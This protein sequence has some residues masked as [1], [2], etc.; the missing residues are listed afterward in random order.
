MSQ[1]PAIQFASQAP[2][3]PAEMLASFGSMFE[4]AFN[5]LGTAGYRRLRPRKMDFLLVDGNNQEII[6][7]DRMFA[8]LIGSAPCNHAVWYERA[9]APGQEPAA[10]D[11]VWKMPTPQ[12]FPDALP[13]QFHQKV[14]KDGREVWAFQQLRR[15]VWALARFNSDGS[16]SLELDRPFVFDISSMSLYGKSLPDQNM[17]KWAGIRDVCAKYSG[18]GV[19]VFP[20]M[21]ITQIVLD[22]TV[23]VNGPVM[24]RPMRDQNGHL[25]FLDTNT[26]IAVHEA[27]QSKQVRDMCDVREKLSYGDSAPVAQ[28]IQSAPQMAQP[29]P[30]TIP[31]VPPAAAAPA[32]NVAPVAQPTASAVSQPTAP[33]MG[34]P[35]QLL[36]NAQQLLQTQTQA[37]TVSTPSVV[38]APAPEPVQQSA[39]GTTASTIAGLISQLS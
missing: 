27:A 12:T 18:N 16:M 21:F 36:A 13:V 35:R 20:S 1:L 2:A 7:N 39:A 24:F 19:T 34:D 25:Q 14:Q 6:A 30:A 31:N 5:D 32:A 8:V 23:T 29:Q 37:A 28:P 11:L 22:T 38:P 33:G 15:T 26:I 17:Y 10:P 4:E 9:Y 3:L